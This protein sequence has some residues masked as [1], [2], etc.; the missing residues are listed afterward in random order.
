MLDRFGLLFLFFAVLG[1]GKN[2][3]GYSAVFS[4]SPDKK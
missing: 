1:W 4:D 2:L 3:F